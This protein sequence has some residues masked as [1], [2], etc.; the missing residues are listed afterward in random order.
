MKRLRRILPLL[1][2]L[3][4]PPVVLWAVWINPV[5]AG[6]DDVVYVYPLRTMVGQALREGRWPGDNPLEATG[7]PLMADPQSAVMFPATW[8]FAVLPPKL[9]YSLSVFLAFS[10]A[11][12]GMYLY[13]RVLGLLRPA[14]TFGAVAFMFCGFMVGHR[15][16]LPMIQTAGFLPWGLWGIE[17]IRRP[18]PGAMGVLAVVFFLAIAAGHW[19]ILTYMGL[20]WAAYLLLRARPLAAAVAMTG[21][22]ALLAAMLAFPQIQAT[23]GLLDQTTR[24]HIG[25]ATAGENSFFPAAA[26]LALFPMLMGNTTPNFYPQ[27][28]WGPWHLWEMLGYVGLV[29]LALAAGAVWT[30]YRRR[31]RGGGVCIGQTQA[32]GEEL[33][34]IV[35]VWTWIGLGAGVWMLGYYLPLFM[36]IHRIPILG[37][38]RCPARMLVVVDLALG[39][40]AAVAVHGVMQAAPDRPRLRRL[41]R[42]VF[43]IA[44]RIVP[45]AMV[46]TLALVAAVTWVVAVVTGPIPLPFAGGPTKAWAA[47]RLG[48]PAIWVPLVLTVATVAVIRL[49]TAAPARRWWIV[50][51]LLGVDLFSVAGFLDAPADLH[52]GPDPD[53]S[54]AAVWLAEHGPPEPY[55]VFGLNDHYRDRPAELLQPK[56]A[57]A[58]GV[59]TLGSY[60][61]WHSPA[62]AHL[63]GFDNYGRCHEWAWLVRRNHLLSLYNVR[64]LVAAG[65]EFRGVIESVR[66]EPPTPLG[67]NVLSGRWELRHAQIGDDGGVRLRTPFLWR[68][69]QARQEIVLPAGGLYRI[70]LDARGPER[71]AGNLLRAE[72]LG[73]LPD[74]RDDV[75]TALGL[76]VIEERI[77]P[78]WR[79][80][81]WTMQVPA[82]LAGRCV[83]RLSSMSERPID[84]RNV[85]LRQAGWETPVSLLGALPQGE[86]VYR[87]VAELPPLNTGD[88]PVAI[89]ENRLCRPKAPLE[90]PG[91][92][93]EAAIE[94]LR[95]MTAEDPVDMS[96]LVQVPDVSLHRL[97]S[98]SALVWWTT[99]P[100]VA[101]LGLVGLAAGVCRRRGRANRQ[102]TD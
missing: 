97:A 87:K 92:A 85:S 22:A 20:A 5:S 4:A 32:D 69:S 23:L 47:L 56:V 95:W 51:A 13:L 34:R 43:A 84:V 67:D 19:A 3:G 54:P 66:V 31:P 18:S 38:V 41:A 82:S 37:V 57:Q 52:R 48:N 71:G 100:A 53:R 64:Y 101:L 77:G 88:E 91:P 44:A 15:V 26:V 21:A 62:H 30:L 14:A 8:L 59:A 16:H 74:G 60:G 55:I 68:L 81:E 99:V 7:A 78:A 58:Q 2:I 25:Y 73:V 96:L 61:A 76:T 42:T 90:I 36:L 11:G 80:F 9:A 39:V 35:R 83:F 27:K 40:L 29:T 46:V 72:V 94:R 50:I 93:E 102:R 86:A 98:P 6:E 33:T 65:R 75:E 12:G 1:L 28:W 45:A 24:R 17:R 89:Y 79:H 70:A 10:V 49:W 63:F